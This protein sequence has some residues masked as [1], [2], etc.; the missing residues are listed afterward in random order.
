MITMYY[1]MLY[2]C[3]FLSCVIVSIYT[4]PADYMFPFSDYFTTTVVSVPSMGNEPRCVVLI[5]ALLS[6]V[7]LAARDD[8]FRFV[9]FVD[10]G[11]DGKGVSCLFS[12]PCW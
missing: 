9:P 7:H 2:F 8:R 10:N 3:V 4:V 5:V 1:C 12:P 11:V 6:A